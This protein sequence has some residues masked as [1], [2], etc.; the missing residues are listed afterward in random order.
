MK[1]WLMDNTNMVFVFEK[2]ISFHDLI[3][4]ADMAILI[5]NAQKKFIPVSLDNAE[6]TK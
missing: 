1:I 5:S 3:Y 4:V 6:N 2:K